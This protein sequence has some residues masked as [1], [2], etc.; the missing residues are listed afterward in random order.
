M[1]IYSGVEDIVIDNDIKFNHD[2]ENTYIINDYRFQ[3]KHQN[4]IL[5]IKVLQLKSIVSY[6]CVFSNDKLKN[7]ANTKT[8]SSL[9]IIYNM[10]IDCF[11]KT[12]DKTLSMIIKHENTDITIDLCYSSKNLTRT[13]TLIVEREEIDQVEVIL[14]NK[15]QSLS[16]RVAN[17]ESIMN[18]VMKEFEKVK[19]YD[20][21]QFYDTT[22][23]RYVIVG[24][25]FM[26]NVIKKPFNYGEVGNIIIYNCNREN[27]DGDHSIKYNINYGT[28]CNN[29]PGKYN[30][31]YH[32]IIESKQKLL[33]VSQSVFPLDKL[34]TIIHKFYNLEN[35]IIEEGII[36]AYDNSLL[37]QI[38]RTPSIKNLRL[39]YFEKP[40]IKTSNII[41]INIDNIGSFVG[42]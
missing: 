32:T 36:K 19:D 30:N 37:F 33:W 25:D 4:N 18:N 31:M 15:I 21:V 24:I 2:S 7:Y 3:F 5:K 11:K 35:F 9:D 22:A 6:N 28:K 39:S 1:S 8:F 13:I 10:L 42:E 27:C 12:N 34:T 40:D 20:L 38:K 14:K 41:N 26:D 16:N 29:Y 23:V 17:L